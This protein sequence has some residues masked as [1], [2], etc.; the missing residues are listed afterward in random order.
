[1]SQQE[2]GRLAGKV[3]IVTGAGGDIGAAIA[4]RFAEEGAAV[5]CADIRGDAA[6]AT[7][8]TIAAAG[9]RAAP[10]ICDV[11]DGTAA[12]ATIEAAVSRFGAL[13]ILVNNAAFF[14]PDQTIVELDEALFARSFAV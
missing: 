12:K 14:I 13:H 2:G 1:M 5:L 3:A 7:A 4:R 11:G 10:A 6:A 8:E 9:G